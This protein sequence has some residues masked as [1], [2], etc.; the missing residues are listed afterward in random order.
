MRKHFERI[1]NEMEAAFAGVAAGNMMGSPALTCR[2]KVFAFFHENEMIFKL[3]QTTAD[4]M[5]KYPGSRFL[6]PFK[7]KPPMKGWLVVP[8]EYH[9]EWASL[10][11]AAYENIV[12]K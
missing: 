12:E 6:N 1:Q 10:A 7:K 4:Y 5:G 3:G 2:S 8:C 9:N 11:V